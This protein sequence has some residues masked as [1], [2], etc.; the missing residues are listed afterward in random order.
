ML[1]H[2]DPCTVGT[3]GNHQSILIEGPGAKPCEGADYEIR[4]GAEAGLVRLRQKVGDK[5]LQPGRWRSIK[6]NH[7]E[8]QTPL[9]LLHSEVRHRVVLAQE[10]SE[11]ERDSPDHEDC[12]SEEPS[13]INH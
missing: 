5:V 4:L 9:R 10:S 6:E 7:K 2:Q 8:V 13:I 11:P 1:H 3:L 12:E